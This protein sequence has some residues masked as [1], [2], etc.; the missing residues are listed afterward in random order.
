[1]LSGRPP[2]GKSGPLVSRTGRI[3]SGRPPED[4]KRH[5]ER[6]TLAVRL[7]DGVDAGRVGLEPVPA[8]PTQ[9]VSQLTHA[10][11]KR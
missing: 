8:E 7:F 6:C 5:A 3:F 9:R 10:V 4:A 2:L 11:R 1:M